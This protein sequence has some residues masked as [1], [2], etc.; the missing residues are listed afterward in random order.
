MIMKKFK[1]TFLN[2]GNKEDIFIAEAETQEA[3]VEDM[4]TR[5][6]GHIG[7]IFKNAKII[8]IKEIQI[9]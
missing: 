2:E 6:I 9:I 7:E 5:F 1:I 3:A 8:S 4:R